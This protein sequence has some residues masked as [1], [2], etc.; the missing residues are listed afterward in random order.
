VGESH[1]VSVGQA[2]SDAFGFNETT[3]FSLGI[4][5]NSINNVVTMS[6]GHAINMSKILADSATLSESFSAVL[7]GGSSSVLNEKVLNTSTLNS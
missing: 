3:V 7:L 1:T 2:S 5:T 4:T 6:E